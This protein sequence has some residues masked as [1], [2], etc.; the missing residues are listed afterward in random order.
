MTEKDLL[1]AGGCIGFIAGWLAHS[2]SDWLGLG[3]C[4][5]C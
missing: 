5:V 2:L 3:L 1:L 4:F